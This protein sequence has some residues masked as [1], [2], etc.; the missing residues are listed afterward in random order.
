M[1]PILYFTGMT[2]LIVGVACSPK[3]DHNAN[4]YYYWERDNVVI[5]LDRL[6]AP[7]SRWDW[8]IDA[9]NNG[10][11]GASHG[12]SNG[13]VLTD[14]CITS[15]VQGSIAVQRAGG[16]VVLIGASTSW[17]VEQAAV[18]AAH[19]REHI[20]MWSQLQQPG[21]VD[22]DGDRLADSREGTPP[23]NLIIGNTDTYQ[24]GVFIHSGY[25]GYGDNEFLARVA[26]SAGLA[27]AQLNLDWSE[28]GPQWRH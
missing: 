2:W 28:G 6:G 3:P 12:P 11:Y 1:K 27:D 22:T 10:V 20:A 7:A 8:D 15:P 13:Y 9:A 14:L 23:H 21:Q 4:W 24:L 26:E 25:A 5:G 19:E 18:T 17:G 16:P